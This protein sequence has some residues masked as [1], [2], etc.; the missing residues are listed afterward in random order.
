MGSLHTIIEI[1]AP[2]AVVRKKFLDF[3]SLATYHPNG[4][5]ASITPADPTIT[6][7]DLKPGD[8]LHCA[9]GH[10][11]LKFSPRV[12][13]NSPEEFSWYADLPEFLPW[14]FGGTHYF[15]FE[16]VGGRAGSGEGVRTRLVHGEN[17][18]GLLAGVYGEGWLSRM[19]GL[20]KEGEQGFRA[21]ND[22]LKRW[23]EREQERGQ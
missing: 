8:K 6:P 20:K 17:F 1:N 21:F 2:P 12:V 14:I 10:G 11:R 15:R 16:G 13:H 5:V 4:F 18:T 22:D 19:V 23:V 9:M 3:S 7:L